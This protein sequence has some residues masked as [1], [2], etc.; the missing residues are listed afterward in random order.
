M[1]ITRTA[2]VPWMWLVTTVAITTVVIALGRFRSNE[3]IAQAIAT[4][5]RRRRGEP[6]AAALLINAKQTNESSPT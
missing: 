6:T 2:K 5:V 3:R 1:R 4:G